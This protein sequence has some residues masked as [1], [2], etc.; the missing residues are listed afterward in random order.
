MLREPMSQLVSAPAFRRI[1]SIHSSDHT[2]HPAHYL[3]HFRQAL[4]QETDLL[5][6][7]QCPAGK[8]DSD[9]VY[10]LIKPHQIGCHQFALTIESQW[11]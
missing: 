9:Y 6:D 5:L 1:R 10:A 3:P 7:L 2:P 4:W 8:D 11:P